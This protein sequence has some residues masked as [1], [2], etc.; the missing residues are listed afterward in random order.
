MP[1]T[2]T[3]DDIAES[4]KCLQNPC[5]DEKERM[6]IAVLAAAYALKDAGGE[7]F[8]ADLDGL[9]AASVGIEVVGHNVVEAEELA[10]TLSVDVGQPATLDELLDAVKCLRC[11]S[12]KALRKALLFLQ[13]AT[14]AEA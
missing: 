12:L 5:I 13:C 4:A 2:C 10:V 3:A 1:L 6:A 8:T 11:Q 7:D 9:I 14:A